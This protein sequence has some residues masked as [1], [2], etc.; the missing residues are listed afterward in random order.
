MTTGPKGQERCCS[1]PD[2]L[3]A[4]ASAMTT[5]AASTATIMNSSSLT[6][7]EASK[8]VG[9]TQT[10]YTTTVIDTTLKRSQA[11]ANHMVHTALQTKTLTADP[12]GLIKPSSQ[13]KPTS[14]SYCAKGKQTQNMLYRSP[15]INNVQDNTAGMGHSTIPVQQKPYGLKKSYSNAGQMSFTNP[16]TTAPTAPTTCYYHPYECGAVS[17]GHQKPQTG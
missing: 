17:A 14:F 1:I 11:N 3:T 6:K 7:V 13:H 8:Y 2:I 12:S 4:A 9:Q 15:S 5:V 10:G 16:Q